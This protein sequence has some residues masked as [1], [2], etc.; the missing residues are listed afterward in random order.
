MVALD[1]LDDIEDNEP[2]LLCSKYG[3]ACTL[4]ISTGLLLLAQQVLLQTPYNTSIAPILLNA[5]MRAAS[6]QHEDL[7]GI[8]DQCHAF[9]AVLAITARK[10][11]SLVA[12]LCQI[13]ALCAGANTA[14]QQ[15]YAQFG[16]YIGMVAQLINDIIA[17]APGTIDKTDIVLGRPTLPLI[18]AVRYNSVAYVDVTAVRSMLW[19]AGPVHLTWTVA[20]TYR[21]QACALIPLL[22][23][24]LANQTSLAALLPT[25]CWMPEQVVDHD[26]G[27]TDNSNGYTEP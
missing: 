5:G 3:T 7:L 2:S 17:V 21:R 8:S 16:W 24:D 4:N 10:S 27:T 18:S 14:L 12:A 6:G 20:E 1:V 19:S 11:A 15:H 13:G 26:Q 9:D 25:L 23:D 22:T